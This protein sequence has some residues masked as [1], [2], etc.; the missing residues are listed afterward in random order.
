MRKNV[1]SLPNRIAKAISRLV[2]GLLSIMVCPALALALSNTPEW[3]VTDFENTSI[4]VSEI[5]S[6]G[7]PKDGIPSIDSPVFVTAD[8]AND[9]LPGNEPVIA[10]AVGKE[11]KAYPLQILTWHEIVNDKIADKLVT[12]TF[13]P[14]CNASIVFDRMID[15]VEYDFG[16]TGRLRRSDMV[17]YDRNT[18]SWWQQF[19]GQGIIGKMNG[20][21]LA[22]I[23]SVIVSFDAF[24]KQYPDG[25]VLSKKTGYQR[26][27]GRN[28]Y[29]GYDD[30]NSSPFLFRGPVDT[31]L[32]PMERVLSLRSDSA[33]LLFGLSELKKN[34]VI[35]TQFGNKPVAVFSFETAASALDNGTI[36][37]SRAI[38][39]AAVYSSRIDDLELT[40]EIREGYAEDKQTGSHWSI[41]GIAE[42][43]PLAGRKLEQLDAGVHFAFAWLA[44]DPEAKIYSH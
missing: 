7:P 30:I 24:K 11:A 12:V 41:F 23:P 44:F 33:T 1:I 31:R 4:D 9:W 42:I 8:V 15:G 39:S 6:G 34:P 37:E 10:L 13:C 22:Q 32:P 2:A 28:P 3:P 40:F 16:T 38:P 35:N 26:A 36:S 27:Y 25:K 18:E 14:L 43:G 17:M 29:P 20:V 5:M 19:T 21:T